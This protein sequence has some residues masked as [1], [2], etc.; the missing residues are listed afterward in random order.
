MTLPPRSQ[1][2]LEAIEAKRRAG[3]DAARPEAV[4][5]QHALGKLTARER[6]ATLLDTGSFE[7]T[8]A[9]VEPARE[10]F[11]T[12]HLEAPADGVVTGFGRIAGRPVAICAFDFTILSFASSGPQSRNCTVGA[13]RAISCMKA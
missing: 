1:S 7:E 9:L 3:L 10:T 12:Q 2:E 5:R 11:D 4:A 13:S 6:I 8:G